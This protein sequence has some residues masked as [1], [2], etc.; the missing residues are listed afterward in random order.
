[1][2]RRSSLLLGLAFGLLIGVFILSG[3]VLHRDNRRIYAD[4]EAIQNSAGTADRLFG[5]IRSEVYLLAI[6]VR[7]YLL[8]TSTL[9]NAQERQNLLDVRA[10][11]LRHVGE[12]QTVVNS[13]GYDRLTAVVQQYVGSTDVLFG[14]TPEEKAAR[15]YG[16]LRREIVPFR[17]AVLSI[18]DEIANVHAAQLSKRRDEIR[19]VQQQAQVHLIWT[20][21]FVSLFGILIAGL[22]IVRTRTLEQR[23]EAYQTELAADRTELRRLS[24]KLVLAQED[25]R[26]LISRELHDQIGQLITGIKI[27]VQ[28]AEESARLSVEESSGHLARARAMAE[29]TLRAVRDL[30]TGLRPAVL[31]QLGLGPALQWQAREHTRL[32]GVPVTVQIYGELNELPE[33]H[34][35]CVYRVVQEALTNSARHADARTVR[36]TVSRS[37][38]SLRVAI[39]DDGRGLGPAPVKSTGLGLV[40]IEERVSELGGLLEIDSAPGQGTAIRIELP[41]QQIIT[42]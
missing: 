32:T 22:V 27:E 37:L 8:A 30:A 31:D 20:V 15:S 4:V 25:E 34:R 41:I 10:S 38:G 3:L 16:Y 24:N 7:D 19:T 26:R 33:P 12:L 29:E 9:T 11:L 28:N 13:S 17:N 23:S 6:L 39:E 1:V 35:T 36:L 14:W 18:A 5:A 42:V 2:W 21:A 40:G